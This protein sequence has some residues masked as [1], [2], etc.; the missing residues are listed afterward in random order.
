MRFARVNNLVVGRRLVNIGVVR[1]VD[2]PPTLYN[3]PVMNAIMQVGAEG[4][5]G[6]GR[7][8]A[9]AQ[10][11]LIDWCWAAD[12]L[13]SAFVGVWLYWGALVCP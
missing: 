8:C 4:R 1:M 6:G 2:L 10:K 9:R 11:R 3:R 5:Q 7:A 13:P 12:P